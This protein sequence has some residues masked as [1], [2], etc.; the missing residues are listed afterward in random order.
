MSHSSRPNTISLRS[1]L[2]SWR[3]KGGVLFGFKKR[4]RRRLRET[5]LRPE[6]VALLERNLPY[7]AALP[8]K[9]RRELQGLVQIFLAEKSFTGC[10]GLEI[11]EEIRLTIAAQACMLLLR[12]KIDRVYPGL[13][14]VLVY[15]SAYIARA[16]RLGA[17]G[18]MIEGRQVRLGESWD[19]GSLV[20]SWDDV[21]QGAADVHDGHNVVFHEFAHQLDQQAGGGP[22]A[23]ELGSRSRYIAWA[24][25]LGNEYEELTRAV[26]A[27]RNTLIDSYG[28]TNP[29]EFFA[30]VTECFFE[31]GVQLR[32]RHP[33]VYQQ[34]CGFYARDPAALELGEA[35]QIPS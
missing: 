22:G 19:R 20:L 1:R 2:L 27:H 25:A 28:A 23:P 5:P 30:V 31:K 12:R 35:E 15:P 18:I 4:Q 29:A 21:Q 33:E 32:K 10:G 26:Y 24:R 9:D 16:P 17:G 34:L 6:A 8:P 3:G 11:T 13:Y 14:S 7:L